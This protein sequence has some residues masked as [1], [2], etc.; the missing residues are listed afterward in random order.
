M[1]KRVRLGYY[2]PNVKGGWRGKQQKEQTW[3]G[4]PS[5]FSAKTVYTTALSLRKVSKG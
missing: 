5:L 4:A 1:K 2:Y 3:G